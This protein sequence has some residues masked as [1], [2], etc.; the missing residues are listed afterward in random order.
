MQDGIGVFN[1]RDGQLDFVMVSATQ[2]FV[3]TSS[4]DGAIY[5]IGVGVVP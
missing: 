3:Y 1:P 4:I 5:L 2:G